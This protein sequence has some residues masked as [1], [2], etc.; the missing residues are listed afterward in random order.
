MFGFGVGKI[1]VKLNKFN[2]KPGDTIE[3]TVSLT[4]K[5][6]SKANG[7]KVAFVGTE[8]SSYRGANGRN[9][10]STKTICNVEQ[11][12]DSEREYEATQMPRDYPFKIVIPSDALRGTSTGNQTADQVVGVFNMLSKSRKRTKWSIKTKLDI[13]MGLDVAKEIQI[14]LNT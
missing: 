2:F 7:V 4:I 8:T 13:P 12:L 6:N 9:Q 3:G 14:N 11:E 10:T 1:D 5:K